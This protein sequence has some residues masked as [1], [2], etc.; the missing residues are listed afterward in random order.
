VFL[1]S[2]NTE[3][4]NKVKKHKLGLVNVSEMLAFRHCDSQAI[5]RPIQAESTKVTCV[6][7][8]FYGSLL[9]YYKIT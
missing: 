1:H 4:W 8:N 9:I 7:D 3:H 2:E 5:P 6:Y